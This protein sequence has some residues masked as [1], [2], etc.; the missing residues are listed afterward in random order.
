MSSIGALISIASRELL[1]VICREMGGG[2]LAAMF[3]RLASSC[4]YSTLHPGG[5]LILYHNVFPLF[6]M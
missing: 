4:F 3:S 1:C 6:S 2:G 5:Y